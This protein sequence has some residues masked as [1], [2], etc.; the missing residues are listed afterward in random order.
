[1][2]RRT[3]VMGIGILVALF[4]FAELIS[5]LLE[6]NPPTISEPPWN[7]PQTRALAVRACFDCHSN[8]TRWPWYS[9]V[10]PV[11]MLIVW[12][13][14][15]GRNRL[16]FSSYRPGQPIGEG[17]GEGGRRG[18]NE[19]ARVIDRGDMP[20]WY[21]LLLHPDAKLT[22]AEKQQLIQGLQASLQ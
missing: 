21:Y 20:P 12:D 9:R 7:S 4:L 3:V 18:G 16:N 19:F 17:E 2:T 1:M 15:R 8:E 14:V 6:T 10:A 5:L 11:S 13:M 22:D